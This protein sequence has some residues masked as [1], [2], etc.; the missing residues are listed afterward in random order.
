MVPAQPERAGSTVVANFL[1]ERIAAQCAAPVQ[2]K[3]GLAHSGVVDK[4]GCMS[5]RL[6]QG[7]LAAAS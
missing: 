7:Q 5:K 1:A 4:E 2:T 6:W 3:S